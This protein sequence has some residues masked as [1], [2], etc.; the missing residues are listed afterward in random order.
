LR[1]RVLREIHR[2]LPSIGSGD[3]TGDVEE[4]IVPHDI[5]HVC[6]TELLHLLETSDSNDEGTLRYNRRYIHAGLY[7][8]REHQQS[9]GPVLIAIDTSG[10]MSSLQLGC[11]ERFLDQ[12]RARHVHGSVID[13]DASV[14]NERA[15]SEFDPSAAGRQQGGAFRRGRGGTDIRVP[16]QHLEQSTRMFRLMLVITDG[17]GPMPA[18]APGIPVV[19]IDVLPEKR[20]DSGAK[21]APRFRPPFG[22]IYAFGPVRIAR[23]EQ[24]P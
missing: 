8:P 17:A 15:L 21:P 3:G 10:S 12:L 9:I 1:K 19:W 24:Y 5:G 23:E 14:T 18:S 11:I 7:L 13:F 4:W 6:I 16:F 2:A 20:I 22:T